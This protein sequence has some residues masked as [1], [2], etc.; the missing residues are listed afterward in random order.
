MQPVRHREVHVRAAGE[1]AHV[2]R[3]GQLDQVR[4]GL[5]VAARGAG[6]QDRVLRR[7]EEAGDFLDAIGRLAMPTLGCMRGRSE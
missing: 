7:R 1:H 5:R 2:Q 3:L 4:D 6:E